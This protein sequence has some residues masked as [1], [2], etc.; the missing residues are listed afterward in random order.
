MHSDL[1][2]QAPHSGLARRNQIRRRDCIRG[3]ARRRH[4]CALNVRQHHAEAPLQFRRAD[5]L[6]SNPPPRCAADRDR[7]R[8]ARPI[9]LGPLPRRELRSGARRL[10][11]ITKSGQPFG[12]VTVQPVPQSLSV[13]ATG[14]RRRL[15]VRAVEYQRKNPRTVLL[16][17]RCARSAVAVKSSRVIVTLALIATRLSRD[18][19]SGQIFSIRESHIRESHKIRQPARPWGNSPVLRL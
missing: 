10:D 11:E 13:H 2:H 5:R 9:Q 17:P 14:L 3:T 19:A 4:R 8:Q 12:V 16:A 1:R 7:P 6:A 18:G 15:A